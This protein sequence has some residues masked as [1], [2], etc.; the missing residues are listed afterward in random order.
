MFMIDCEES[1]RAATASHP[2]DA[3]CH[4][5]RSLKLLFLLLL[6]LHD[7]VAM[8]FPIQPIVMF[9]SDTTV[10]ITALIS[11]FMPIN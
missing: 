9:I 10:T 8:M 6:L 3:Q 7:V 1:S 11:D 4:G 2:A 5:D